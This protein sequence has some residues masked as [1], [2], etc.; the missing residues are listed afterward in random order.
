M[1]EAWLL[2]WRQAPLP[3]AFLIALCLHLTVY[4]G[5]GGVI[6]VFYALLR[7]L[8]WGM[9]LEKRPFYAAQMKNELLRGTA[10]CAIISLVTLACLAQTKRTVPSNPGWAALELVGLI[11]FY[12]PVFYFLHRLLHTKAL[13]AAH[14]IHHRSVRPTPWTG[15][16]VHPIE[17]IFIE[18]PILLFTLLVPTSVLTLV[19]FQI[20][21]HYFSSVGH[22]NFDPFGRLVGFDGLKRMLR[23]HQDHHS[24]SDVNFTAFLPI[25][26][27]I[28][29]TH[30][31]DNI[32]SAEDRT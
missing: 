25:W 31:L 16:S 17:V 12:D 7:R 5:W 15:L 20:V 18:L 13:R 1:I 21:L 8:Q 9:I 2:A 23:W 3:T 32:I 30:G 24:H 14:G 6:A 22:A 27:K 19:L 10:N 26:D 4:L 28:F 11:L 29:N